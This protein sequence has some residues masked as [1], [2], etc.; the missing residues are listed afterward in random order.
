MGG[1][2]LD[3][4]VLYSEGSIKHEVHICCQ[5]LLLRILVSKDES[6]IYF[7]P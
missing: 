2:V 3:T 4:L 7:D 1:S 6:L 5:I